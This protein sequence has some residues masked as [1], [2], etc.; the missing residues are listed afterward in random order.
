MVKSQINTSQILLTIKIISNFFAKNSKSILCCLNCVLG[1]YKFLSI[2]H[3]K[4]F[5]RHSGMKVDCSKHTEC[6]LND[7]TFNKK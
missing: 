1:D 3:R 2:I 5:S 6:Y 7:W 4:S